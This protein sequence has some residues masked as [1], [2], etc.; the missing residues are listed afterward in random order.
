MDTVFS[1]YKHLIH[2][3]TISL[4]T[5]SLGMNGKCLKSY[6]CNGDSINCLKVK[7]LVAQ[8]C[9][10]LFHPMDCSPL[11]SSVHGILQARILEWVAIPFL[12][13]SSQPRD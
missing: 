1:V 4:L 2:R 13:V 6:K 5:C 3:I 12:R 9:L 11:G 8:W 7:V 10:T